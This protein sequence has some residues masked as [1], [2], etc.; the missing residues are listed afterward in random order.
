[1]R[2]LVLGAGTKLGAMDRVFLWNRASP[3]VRDPSSD[4]PPRTFTPVCVGQRAFARH[5][6]GDV[7]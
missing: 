3:F 6:D 7:G 1:M 2:G 4:F 5:S